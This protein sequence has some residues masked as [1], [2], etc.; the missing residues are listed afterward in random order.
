M[1]DTLEV[2]LRKYA[3]DKMNAIAENAESYASHLTNEMRRSAR[4]TDQ[5]GEARKGLK[6]VVKKDNGDI[7][8]YLI[9]SVSYA[10]F[11]ERSNHGKYAVLTPIFHKY[12]N[13]P[14]ILAKRG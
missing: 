10:K 11:L 3:K 9:H 7:L 6:C 2:M 4:W 5:S 13:L 14:A 8:I 12:K 1:S